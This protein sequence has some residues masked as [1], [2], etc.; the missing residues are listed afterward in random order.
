MQHTDQLP[1]PERYCARNVIMDLQE[2]ST[3]VSFEVASSIQLSQT[4]GD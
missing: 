3:M 2:L 1:F 4:S